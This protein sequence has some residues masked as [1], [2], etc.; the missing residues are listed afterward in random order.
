MYHFVIWNH[1]LTL[2]IPIFYYFHP[3]CLKKLLILLMQMVNKTIIESHCTKYNLYLYF[4]FS[5]WSCYSS[6]Q[7]DWYSQHHGLGPHRFYR[8]AN[9]IIGDVF[10]Y[11]F[12]FQNILQSGKILIKKTKS[13]Q[14]KLKFP[15]T[16]KVSVT[17]LSRKVINIHYKIISSHSN[18]VMASTDFFYGIADKKSRRLIT[19]P[20]EL[21]SKAKYLE[22]NQ[23]PAVL[24]AGCPPVLS[25]RELV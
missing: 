24:V 18:L 2:L 16:V 21:L 8:P 15:V 23:K 6:G 13:R 19:L 5:R 9:N 22:T 20:K 1:I 17:Y 3:S 7:D 10:R 11:Q 12:S 4:L 14:L 25:G